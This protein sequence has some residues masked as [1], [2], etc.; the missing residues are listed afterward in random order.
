M[1]K[2]DMQKKLIVRAQGNRC[3]ECSNVLK[4]GEQG[5]CKVINKK[6]SP[7]IVP[8]CAKCTFGAISKKKEEQIKS[9][10]NNNVFE[11]KESN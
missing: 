6:T 8:L 10:H 9:A 5:G 11:N 4:V 7:S 2:N 1:D 3:Y